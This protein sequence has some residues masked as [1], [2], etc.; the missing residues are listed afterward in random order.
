[1]KAIELGSCDRQL[2]HPACLQCLKMIVVLTLEVILCLFSDVFLEKLKLFMT[3]PGPSGKLWAGSKG[4]FSRSNRKVS[5][6]EVYLCVLS[7]FVALLKLQ[8]RRGNVGSGG[9]V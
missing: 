5:Q 6:D 8:G 4:F 9:C 2:C 3:F 1:M 7:G